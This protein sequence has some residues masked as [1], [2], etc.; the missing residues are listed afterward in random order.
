[1]PRSIMLNEQ[2][3]IIVTITSDHVHQ[4]K[5]LT[6]KLIH[7]ALSDAGFT[8]VD[9]ITDLDTDALIEEAKDQNHL[10]EHISNVKFHNPKF[11]LIEK[12]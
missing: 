8:D 12:H 1:M 9:V 2:P 4:G 11:I 6:M 3:R 7:K 5:T 10:E